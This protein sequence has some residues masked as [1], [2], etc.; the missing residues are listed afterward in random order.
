LKV[1]S[2]RH[3][4]HLPEPAYQFSAGFAVEMVITAILMGVI[5][6]LTDDGNGMP[7]GPLAPLLIGFL[8]AVIGAHPWAC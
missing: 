1:S 2:W 7:R 5:M 8:I 3:F 6:A 4:L